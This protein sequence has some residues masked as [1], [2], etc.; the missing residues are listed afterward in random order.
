M[1][2]GTL[3]LLIRTLSMAIIT[4][5]EI[6]TAIWVH[7]VLS[8][9]REIGNIAIAPPN[10][11]KTLNSTFSIFFSTE[12]GTWQVCHWIKFW[13]RELT[14]SIFDIFN[15]DGLLFLSNTKDLTKVNFTKDFGHQHTV[16][17]Q[18]RHGVLKFFFR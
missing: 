8:I 13:I 12:I 5:V 9:K 18:K 1:K 6:Q 16:P 17:L 4:I 10:Y 14:R 15:R 2:N 11:Q 7:G 3:S